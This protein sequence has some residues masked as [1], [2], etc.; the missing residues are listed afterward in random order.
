MGAVHGLSLKLAFPTGDQAFLRTWMNQEVAEV[1]VGQR[2]PLRNAV[3][4]NPR[5]LLGLDLGA[6]RKS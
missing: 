1:H 4:W 6:E 5:G 2:A 3:L